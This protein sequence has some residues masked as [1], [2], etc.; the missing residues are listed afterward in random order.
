[1]VT[2]T[3]EKLWTDTCTVIEYQEY[4]K[5]NKST[6]HKEVA[7]LEN[8]PCKLSFKL[9]YAVDQTD[10]GAHPSQVAKLFLDNS[11]VINPGSKITVFHQ[12]REFEFS[13][14]GLPGVFSNHQEIVLVPFKG[15]A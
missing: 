8:Q 15:W 1:M 13:N 4:I 6:G 3:L 7:V 9:L 5:A 12:G 2:N 11:A 14:S 10:S